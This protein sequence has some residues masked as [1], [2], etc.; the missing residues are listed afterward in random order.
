M[1]AAPIDREKSPR[2]WVGAGAGL[3]VMAIGLVCL[4]LPSAPVRVLSAMLGLALIVSG[5]RLAVDGRIRATSDPDPRRAIPVSLA[6]VAAGM[7]VMSRPAF[8]VDA[9]GV[10]AGAASVALGILGVLASTGGDSRP[11]RIPTLVAVALL[12]LGAGLAFAP[13]ID[14]RWLAIALGAC[15]LLAGVECVVAGV[16]PASRS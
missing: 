1:E 2:A 8:V 4:L 6:L 16:A 7:V 11:R 5:L 10:V 15:L 9:F 13:G 12:V 3:I 14:G